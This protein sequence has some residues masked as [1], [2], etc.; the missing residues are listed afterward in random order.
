M[1][2]DLQQPLGAR[3]NSCEVLKGAPDSTKAGE[4][5][6]IRFTQ[7]SQGS[8]RQFKQSRC[9][10]GPTV[11]GLQFGL[12]TGSQS[13]VGNLPYLMAKQV[14]LLSVGSLVHDERGLGLLKARPSAQLFS[15]GLSLGIQPSVGV[16]QAELKPGLE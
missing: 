13:G 7:G 12:L 2:L 10:R 3:I 8:L 5:G 1:D 6:V 9:V 15:K 4:G 11:L 16:Y 14:D